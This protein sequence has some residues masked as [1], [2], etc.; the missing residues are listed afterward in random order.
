MGGGV[1]VGECGKK[2][3]FLL[4]IPTKY[5]IEYTTYTNKLFLVYLEFKFNW[6][7]LFLFAKSGHSGWNASAAH[8]CCWGEGSEAPPGD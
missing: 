5:F 7:S 1:G 3:M 4:K 8:L 6:A 2:G